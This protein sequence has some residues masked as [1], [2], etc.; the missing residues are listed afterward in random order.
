[1]VFLNQQV[2]K[3]TTSIHNIPYL[4]PLSFPFFVLL[5]FARDFIIYIFLD[6]PQALPQ[7]HKPFFVDKYQNIGYADYQR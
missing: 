1:M 4:F 5:V 3:L 2:Y 6:V 7:A